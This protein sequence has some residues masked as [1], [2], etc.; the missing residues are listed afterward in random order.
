MSLLM[1]LIFDAVTLGTCIKSSNL[2]F[3]FTI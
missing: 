3:I 2:E 1:E